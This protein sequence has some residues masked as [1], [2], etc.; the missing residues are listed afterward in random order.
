M[1]KIIF[2]RSLVR[3]P[4]IFEY[5]STEWHYAECSKL[6]SRLWKLGCWQCIST[7]LE[8]IINRVWPKKNRTHHVVILSYM[9]NSFRVL[10]S[11]TREQNL[12][13]QIQNEIRNCCISPRGT[14]KM[15][16]FSTSARQREAH[17]CVPKRCSFIIPLT[18]IQKLYY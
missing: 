12:Q 16:P 14:K 6:Q 1:C 4:D 8:L 15:L 18:L 17:A 10:Y 13:I 3:D 5:F 11:E 7:F 9:E 2:D